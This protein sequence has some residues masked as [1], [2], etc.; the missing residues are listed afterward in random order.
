MNA[1]NNNYLNLLDMKLQL[2]AEERETEFLNVSKI[3]FF[4]MQL[5]IIRIPV[6]FS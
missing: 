1:L 2:P 6:I 5:S 4:E 3:D